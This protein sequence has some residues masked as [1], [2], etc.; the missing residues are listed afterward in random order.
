[1]GP[2]WLATLSVGVFLEPGQWRAP[3]EACG[4]TGELLGGMALRRGEGCVDQPL[5]F[6]PLRRRQ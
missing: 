3:R 4:L 6:F 1:M 5:L 2:Y